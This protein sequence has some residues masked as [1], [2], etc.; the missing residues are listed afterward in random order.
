MSHTPSPSSLPYFISSFFSFFCRHFPVSQ[1]F[2]YTSTSFFCLSV[3]PVVLVQMAVSVVVELNKACF[4]ATLLL[5]CRRVDRCFLLPQI[6][7]RSAWKR[8]RG[9]SMCPSF[10]SPLLSLTL[11]P[12]SQFSS[13]HEDRAL[14]PLLLSAHRADTL[15]TTWLRLLS[16]TLLHHLSFAPRSTLLLS[17]ELIAASLTQ[18]TQL[19]SSLSA[20]QPQ[21]LS[22]QLQLLLS[23]APPQLHSL[24]LSRHAD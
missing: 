10:R 7:S 17:V 1:S 13:P 14:L 11:I 8:M 2:Q 21:S 12:L 23:S 18:L 22:T 19:F 3:E 20:F 16:P 6:S 15:S 4:F 5:Q 9:S 24:S